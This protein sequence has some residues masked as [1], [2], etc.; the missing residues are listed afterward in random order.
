MSSEIKKQIIIAQSQLVDY[1]GSEITTLELSEYFTEEGWDVFIVTNIISDPIKKEFDKL[2][3][4]TILIIDDTSFSKA[5]KGL[6]PYLVWI[7]HQVLPTELVELIQKSSPRVVFHHMS[8]FALAEMP[9]QTELERQFA[10]VV[11]FNSILSREKLLRSGWFDGFA[12]EMLISINNPAP[13]MFYKD[14]LTYDESKKRELNKILI[15]SNHIPEELGEALDLV[16][17]TGIEVERFGTKGDSYKR[18]LPSD[19]TGADLVVTIG[20]TVQYS[21]CANVPVYCYDHFGG[22]GYLDNKNYETVMRHNFSGKGGFGKKTSKGIKREIIED[23][24]AATES[25]EHI[26]SQHAEEFL[27]SKKVAEV[28]RRCEKSGRGDELQLKKPQVLAADAVT[29]LMGERIKNYHSVLAA[30]KAQH[31]KIGELRSER[32]KLRIELDRLRKVQ[33]DN[34]QRAVGGFG[35]TLRRMRNKD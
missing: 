30:K 19:I 25:M 20:K 34:H 12:E 8:S 14:R 27:L 24:V 35:R 33:P 28:L 26:H 23:Y 16:A 29:R 3:S 9:F 2:S 11:S 18:I 31:H 17:N 13:D 5:I 32:N 21:I 4:A 10:D 22:P 7:H 15:V 1:A 6:D